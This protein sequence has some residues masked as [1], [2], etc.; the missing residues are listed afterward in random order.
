MNALLLSLRLIHIVCGVLWVGFGV[1]VALILTPALEELGSDGAKV[2]PALARRGIMTMLP[3][4]ALLTLLSGFWLYGIVSGGF[5]AGYVRSGVGATLLGGGLAAVAAF[6]IGIFSTR[7]SMM[8]VGM[9]MQSLATAAP[10]ARAGIAA[11]AERLRTH[12]A[13]SG[14]YGTILLLLATACMAVARY[15]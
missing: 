5:F 1:F 10:E 2:M 3:L 15:L 9:L 13:T 14:R 7:P 8:K 11:E 4:L 12:G 6:G